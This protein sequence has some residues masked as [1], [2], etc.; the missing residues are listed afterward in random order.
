VFKNR[1]LR[2]ILWP[3]KDEVTVEWRRPDKIE[4]CGLYFSPSIIQVIKS[5]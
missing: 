4:L 2:K 3:K 1:V 5:K